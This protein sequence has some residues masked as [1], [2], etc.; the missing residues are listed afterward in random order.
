MAYAGPASRPSREP[1]PEPSSNPDARRAAYQSHP[2]RQAVPPAPKHVGKPYEV[3][4][5]PTLLFAA[6]LGV[7]ILMG[8][9]AAMLL[10]PESGPDMRRLLARRG[11]RVARR[12][13][14]AWDDLRDE[15]HRAKRM[16]RRRQ[17]A[18]KA[19]VDD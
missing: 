8:A 3:T 18:A 10:T 9:A 2:P 16:L 5:G 4:P 19:A 1:A 14:D 13:G 12:S 11:R 7:G 15:L 6:G 17:R